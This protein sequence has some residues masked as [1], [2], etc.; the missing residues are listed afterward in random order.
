MIRISFFRGKD[1][2][3]RKTVFSLNVIEKFSGY[4]ELGK[5]EEFS[6]TAHILLDTIV[7]NTDD[8][9]FKGQTADRKSVCI[10]CGFF[11]SLRLY[12]FTDNGNE[13]FS[14]FRTETAKRIV[15]GQKT[16]CR[17]SEILIITIHGVLLSL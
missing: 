6:V 5:S 13:F 17:L 3:F 2:G 11:R 9:A 12:I 1:I 10:L 16:S 14:C 4:I 8:T 7:E 15:L